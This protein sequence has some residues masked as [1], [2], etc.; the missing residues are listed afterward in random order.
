VPPAVAL[1]HSGRLREV[2]EPVQRGRHHVGLGVERA[3]PEAD[4]LTVFAVVAPP[5]A[6]EPGEAPGAEAAGEEPGG[7]V[8]PTERHPDAATQ[9]HDV[10]VA[11]VRGA[12]ASAEAE[13]ADQGAQPGVHIGVVV[14]AVGVE[15]LP[16]PGAEVPHPGELR[17][18]VQPGRHGAVA[19]RAA[20]VP[21]Q[22]GEGGG[23][24]PRRPRR[25]HRGRIRA[26]RIAGW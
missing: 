9:D 22:L 25:G 12:V 13:G 2:E 6:G 4:S 8:D 15:P 23:R 17:H 20:E 26:A 3:E 18:P 11:S 16:H 1:V 19:D 21:D 5:Q 24:H 14:D 7:V 10:V